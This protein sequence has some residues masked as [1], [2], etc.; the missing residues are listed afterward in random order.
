MSGALDEIIDDL[1]AE[2]AALA[3][4]LVR[5]DA[6]AWDAPTHGPGWAVRDQVAHL[7][8][9]DESATRAI[10]DPAEIGRASCRERV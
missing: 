4:V 3:G 7:A 1:A 5:L 9:F 2:Q 8:Y 6:A 10:L